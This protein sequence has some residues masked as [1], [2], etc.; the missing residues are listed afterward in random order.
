M[1]LE[2][3]RPL[4]LQ[5]G[6]GE[7]LWVLGDHYTIKVGAEQTGG[8]FAII[9]LVAFP[10][11]SPPL[12]IHHREDESFF[13]MEGTLTCLLGHDVFDAGPGAF[14]HI[15]KGTLHTFKNSGTRPAR[16][17]VTLSPGGFEDFWRKIG[18]PASQSTTPAP[19][20]EGIVQRILALAPQY[21]L[22]VPSN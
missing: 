16:A 18:E 22:E 21:H 14:V 19:P 5:A 15:P 8:A 4:T 3:P 11:S 17:L 12:H 9:E 1:P 7:T 2:N 6:Q 13:V 20:P 10:Q